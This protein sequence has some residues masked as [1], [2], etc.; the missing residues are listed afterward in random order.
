TSTPT[1]TVTVTPTNTAPAPTLT[2]SGT[3]TS[4]ATASA[5]ATAGAQTA[6]PTGTPMSTPLPTTEP[7]P[8]P[9][10][11]SPV[12]GDGAPADGE[13]CTGCPADCI[14][15][16]CTAVTPLRTIAVTL[17]IPPGQSV[18]GTTVT[19]GYDSGVVSLPGSGAVASVASRVKNRPTNITFSVF[20][21]DY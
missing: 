21:F 19:L 8:T 18:N 20:D 7:T 14:I 9:P 10:I 17:S 2:P 11:P 13:T 6:T 3:A 16:H 5:S 1:A 4:T 15:Q 12:C